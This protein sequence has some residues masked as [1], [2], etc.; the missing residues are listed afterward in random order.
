MAARSRPR[1]GT[2]KEDLSD[3]HEEKSM[4]EQIQRDLYKCSQLQ[5]KQRENASKIQELEANMR[6]GRFP[7]FP[8]DVIMSPLLFYPFLT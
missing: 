1:N 2:F 8:L 3:A 6:N 5:T 4:W 7:R